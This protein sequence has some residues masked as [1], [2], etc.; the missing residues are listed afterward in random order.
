MLE[1]MT[2]IRRGHHRRPV[3]LRIEVTLDGA[4]DLAQAFPWDDQFSLAIGRKLAEADA[5]IAELDSHEEPGIQIVVSERRL[6]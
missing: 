2:I 1:S 6:R 4:L 5:I 3:G